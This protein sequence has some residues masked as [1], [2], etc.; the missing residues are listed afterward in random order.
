MNGPTKYILWFLM[1]IIAGFWIRAGI[2]LLY[3]WRTVEIHSI[4][5]YDDDNVVVAGEPVVYQVHYTKYTNER[6]E[7]NRELINHATIKMAQTTGINRAGEGYV[8]AEV[9]TPSFVDTGDYKIRITYSYVLFSFPERRI[10]VVA[11]TP[12]FHIINPRATIDTVIINQAGINREEI[13]R[14]KVKLDELEKSLK[15]IDKKADRADP[16]NK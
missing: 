11:M 14:N 6:P 1:A 16:R 13:N 10:D 2:I 9:P 7:I 12:P 4:R 5:I 8:M 3:P 15:K